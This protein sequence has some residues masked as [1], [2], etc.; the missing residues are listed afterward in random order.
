MSL[1]LDALRKSERTRQ[2]SLT[3]QLGA[4]EAPPAPAR[5]AL[6]WTTML[7]LLLLVN[8]LV[9]ALFF[10]RNGDQEPAAPAP[11][12]TALQSQAAPYRPEVRP[13]S[14]EAPSADGAGVAGPVAV[15]QAAPKATARSATP[16]VAPVVAQN[17]S[18]DLPSY[19]SLPADF[20]QSL[21]A[22]HLDVHGYT[23]KP[24]ERFVVINLQRYRIG[25]SLPDGP[26]V[27]DIVP[28]GVI[29]EFRGTRFLL[30]P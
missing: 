20:R 2:Q 19:D 25:D 21:P 26:Q 30:P 24:D 13:L 15:P 4:G 8:A 3:G 28:Q 10:W 7:G 1:I 11:Q 18:A 9:L 27:V 29:L 17:S 16:P 22:L 14:E 5:F 6:P 12:A 23:A